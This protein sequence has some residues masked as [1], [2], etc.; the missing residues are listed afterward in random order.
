MTCMYPMGN[1]HFIKSMYLC[2]STA[3]KIKLLEKLVYSISETSC[4]KLWR[5]TDACTCDMKKRK[6]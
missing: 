1:I 6:L 3:Q 2:F 4:K 5:W